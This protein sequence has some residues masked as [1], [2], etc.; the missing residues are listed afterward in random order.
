[1]LFILSWG[2]IFYLVA[3]F[4]VRRTSFS[5]SCSASPLAMNYL[6][7]LCAKLSLVLK[8]IFSGYRIF[9][10]QDI[11]LALYEGDLLLSSDPI[12]SDEK[13]VAICIIVTL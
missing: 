6:S 5:T 1:M 8:N 4:S 10:W 11:S 7:F 2:C 13:S 12:V 9:N 3:F